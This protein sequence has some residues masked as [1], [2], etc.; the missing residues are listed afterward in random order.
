MKLL[1]SYANSVSVDIKSA[2]IL[3]AQFYPAPDKYITIQNSSGMPAKDYDLWQ[4]VIDLIYPYLEPAGIS[5]IQIG[6]GDIKP[7]SKVNNL[8]NQTSF[9]Q[10]VY[11]LNNAL[12]HCGNDSWAAHSCSENTPCVILYG[13]TSVDCHSPYFHHIKS[14]F[15]S[16][17]RCG[18]N[19][20]FQAFES[21]KSVNYIKPEVVANSILN[22]LFSNDNSQ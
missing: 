8:T 19:P 7:L 3:P 4:L 5:I 22:I 21:P 9:A 2:P 17:H 16:S 10:S 12:L 6:K 11:L 20:S 14:Q 18:K 15:I 1:E 13:S